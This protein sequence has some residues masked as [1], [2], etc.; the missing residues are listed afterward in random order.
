MQA[1]LLPARRVNQIAAASG[2]LIDSMKSHPALVGYKCPTEVRVVGQ[3]LLT[4]A[5]KLDRM[6]L[7]RA[8]CGEQELATGCADMHR[9]RRNDES[10]I[11]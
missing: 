9:S 3:L 1:G 5:Q 2:K 10:S 6:A 11:G 7:R 4:G 8:A